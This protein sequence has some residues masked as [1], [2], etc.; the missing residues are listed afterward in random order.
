MI[1]TSTHGQDAVGHSRNEKARWAE[2]H[3]ARF[4]FLFDRPAGLALQADSSVTVTPF[5]GFRPIEPR[6]T[7]GIDILQRLP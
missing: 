7:D 6:C 2:T 4:V 1:A 5:R 3:R